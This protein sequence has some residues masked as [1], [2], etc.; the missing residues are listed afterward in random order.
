VLLSD[1]LGALSTAG[2]GVAWDAGAP[3]ATAVALDGDRLVAVPL[4][5]AEPTQDLTRPAA[6]PSGSP[7]PLGGSLDE[8]GRQRFDSFARLMLTADL[9]GTAGGVLADAVH[10]AGD[11]VQFG[12][13]IGKFQAV[14]H[15]AARAYGEVE[16]IRSS[17]L[18]GAWSL[19]AGREHREASLV[20]KAYA[21]RAGVAVVEAAVQVYGGVAITWEFRAHRHLRRAL[22]DAL[23][24]GGP[25]AAGEELLVAIEA[26]E[27]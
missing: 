16:A 14:Q 10:Y 5:A 24:L 2:T 12:V 26:E 15:L 27:G 7:E 23:V 22:L 1:D 9:L 18:H 6:R 13:P 4:A 20:A 25:D 19:D 11:R 17:L 3:V 8:E 21:G